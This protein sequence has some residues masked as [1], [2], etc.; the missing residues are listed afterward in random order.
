MKV[1]VWYVPEC[2]A[3]LPAVRLLKDV[4]AEEG[5]S[6][7]I[8]EILVADAQMASEIKFRGSPTIRVNGLDI[9]EDTSCPGTISC[10]WYPGSQP[11][12][13]PPVEMVRRALLRAAKT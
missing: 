1:E 2:P 8:A 13:I 11:A 9:A 3:H 5:L 7:E 6:A 10:R 12:G 4:L